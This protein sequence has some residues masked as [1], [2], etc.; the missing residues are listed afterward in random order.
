MSDVHSQTPTQMR[1]LLR[2]G[3]CIYSAAANRM[4]ALGF[5]ANVRTLRLDVEFVVSMVAIYVV[6]GDRRLQWACGT[7]PAPAG[8]NYRRGEKGDSCVTLFSGHS[9]DEVTSFVD[10]LSS[11]KRTA[12]PIPTSWKPE[13]DP[14]SL[15]TAEANHV[16]SHIRMA[17]ALA[18][19][20]ADAALWARRTERLR[21]AVL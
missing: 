21:P 16:E 5:D 3:Q 6:M 7:P 9:D 18:F 12:S 20:G 15:A 11:P 1:P 2:S 4:V 19:P 10:A 17:A 14:H 8:F 13:W